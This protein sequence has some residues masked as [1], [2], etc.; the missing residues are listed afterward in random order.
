M[1][2]PEAEQGPE[3]SPLGDVAS[4][5]G[6][7]AAVQE[8]EEEEG[9]GEDDDATP[10]EV[11]V[12]WSMSSSRFSR[13]QTRTVHRRCLLTFLVPQEGAATP[14]KQEA[15]EDWDM[16]IKTTLYSPDGVQEEVEISVNNYGGAL[17]PHGGG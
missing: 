14:E 6:A 10:D 13:T 3:I 11:I 8:K 17:A 5:G 16:K 1:D 12:C 4:P 15:E 9:G 2:K 7:A